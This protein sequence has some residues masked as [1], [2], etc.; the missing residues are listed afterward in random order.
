MKK[1]SVLY[2]IN[3]KFVNAE[4]KS[5]E[6]RAKIEELF[7]MKPVEKKSEEKREHH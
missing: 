5:N 7:Q 2:E 6:F 4:D 3:N 1:K